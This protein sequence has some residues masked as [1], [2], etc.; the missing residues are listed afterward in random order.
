MMPVD[1]KQDQQKVQHN[2]KQTQSHTSYRWNQ[3]Q[4]KSCDIRGCINNLKPALF[5]Y[6]K[7]VWLYLILHGTCTK[8]Q[9]SLS[10]LVESAW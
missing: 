2:T 10:E 7:L 6:Y 3:L 4:I 8:V 1:N 9:K 5:T